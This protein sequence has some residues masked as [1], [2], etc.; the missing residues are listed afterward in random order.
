M[1]VVALGLLGLVRA[2]ENSIPL[3]YALASDLT[4]QIPISI[5]FTHTQI[6]ATKPTDTL[7]LLNFSLTVNMED[8]PAN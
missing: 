2:I 1:F 6:Y 4:S 8:F 7:H 3:S 5:S